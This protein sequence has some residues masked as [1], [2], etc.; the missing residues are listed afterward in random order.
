MLATLHLLARDSLNGRDAGPFEASTGTL[1]FVFFVLL[2]L[3]TA[4]SIS[5]LH[6]RR[7]RLAR[8]QGLLP[9]SNHTAHRRSA[10]INRTCSFGRN[11]AVFVYS[12]SSPSTP[13]P[14]IR[15]TFPDDDDQ[16]AARKQ[17]RVVVVH[18]TDTGSV[19]M[20]PLDED[21]LPPYQRGD[22]NGFQSLDLNRMGGLREKEPLSSQR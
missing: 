6:L 3:A 8:E 2:F 1:V 7:R 10:P 5:L 20:S 11:D 18:V 22:A 15:V 9:T 12:S 21:Q 16:K 19:G 4:L 14:E 17:G 13:V